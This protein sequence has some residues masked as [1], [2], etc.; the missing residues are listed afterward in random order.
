[1]FGVIDTSE[2]LITG[3][4]IE[5]LDLDEVKKHLRFGPTSEDTLIDAWISAA[6]QYFEQ[7]T[8]RQL[9][10]ATWEYALDRFPCDR[11]IELPHPPLISVES[12]TY[13]D[14]SATEQTLD[15]ANYAVSAPSGPQATRGRISLL[16]GLTWPQT[17]L[18]AKAVRIRFVAGYGAAIGDVPEIVKTALYL[19]V[20]TFHKYRSEVH[21]Q[22]AGGSLVKLPLG[23]EELVRSYAGTALPTLEPRR[24]PYGA[25]HGWL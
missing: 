25:V 16:S 23:V 12:V 17:V 2:R 10:A 9:I 7:A 11:S 8:G 1:M 14:A 15:P 24:W 6:R 19:L 3:P 18:Q 5:P 13:D 21:E 20:A 4:A 22:I